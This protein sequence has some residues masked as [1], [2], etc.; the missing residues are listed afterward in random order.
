MYEVV[1]MIYRTRT[2]IAGARDEDEDAINQLY[3]WKNSN[4]WSLDFVDAH[5]FVQSRDTSNSCSIKHSLCDRM[6]HSK[7]F[8]LIVGPKTNKVK[9]GSC[10]YCSHYYNGR[11]YSG[12]SLS[13][14]SFIEYE[15]DK[16]IR[17]GMKIIVLYNSSYVCKD[18]CPQIIK[19]KGI[20]VA[21]KNAYGWDY[22][23]VKAAFDYYG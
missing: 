19:Y 5:E 7:L 11:C 22:T 6:Q 1:E 10:L 20:H 16:A 21:M 9:S 18:W 4:Y 2:Y 8:V 15:C 3:K 17:D 13:F 23:K 14:N 12:N